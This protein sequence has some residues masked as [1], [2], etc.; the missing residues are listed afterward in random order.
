MNLLK[1]I[2][3]IS[4]LITSCN[5]NSD[6]STNGA[7]RNIE[8]IVKNDSA[9]SK[10]Y[11]SSLKASSYAAKFYLIDSM[12]IAKDTNY[13]PTNLTLNEQYNFTL[14]KDPVSLRIKRINYSTIHY[15]LIGPNK[16]IEEDY[17]DLTP[18]FFLKNEPEYIS[19]AKNIVIK[20]KSYT[21]NKTKL[22][23][24]FLHHQKGTGNIDYSK[25]FY[26]E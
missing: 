18:L 21:T 9:Y 22:E 6:T 8:V 3:A 13:F 25:T 12:V 5:K 4:L 23:A 20:I 2:I 7:E 24:S 14:A 11:I 17:A 10:K 19:R 15:S 26:A 1:S 16:F